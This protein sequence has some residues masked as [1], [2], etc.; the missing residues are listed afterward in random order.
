[1]SVKSSILLTF[2]Q[3]LQEKVSR[4]WISTEFDTDSDTADVI[5]LK[6]MIFLQQFIAPTASNNHVCSG[7]TDGWGG[8]CSLNRLFY[9][10]GGFSVVKAKT[11][12]K[13]VLCLYEGLLTSRCPG[14]LTNS[15]FLLLI[16][17][18]MP[19]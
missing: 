14:R 15:M 5:F 10:K 4:D 2:F 8:V 12:N 19:E 7:H 9:Q 17:Y 11:E 13:I 18:A 3:D 16:C 1:M 6:I